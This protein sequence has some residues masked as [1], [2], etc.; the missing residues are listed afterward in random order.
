MSIA[1]G[2]VEHLN[3]M[4][5][6]LP[7]VPD[8]KLI[9]V[10]EALRVPGASDNMRKAEG[11][12]V[13]E[14]ISA[15]VSSLPSTLTEAVRTVLEASGTAHTGEI[16]RAIERQGL[17]YLS[18]GR[19]LYGSV[20]RVL[21]RG[22]FER[23]HRGL[24]QLEQLEVKPKNANTAQLKMALKKMAKFPGPFCAKEIAA[25]LGLTTKEV[26]SLL[27]SL[28]KEGQIKIVSKNK[29]GTANWNWVGK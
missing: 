6:Q 17:G 23:V 10:A 1:F 13:E 9:L 3:M 12:E 14:G 21:N 7:G 29:S 2:L 20:M 4:R 22:P 11:P 8:D 27:K 26:T 19:Q 16:A 24:W 25:Y 5:S 28:H 18:N 15:Q